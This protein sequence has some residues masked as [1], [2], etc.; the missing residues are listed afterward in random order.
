MANLL[1]T[2]ILRPAGRYVTVV[3]YKPDEQSEKGIVLPEQAR[4]KYTAGVIRDVGPDCNT[5]TQGEHV[6]YSVFGGIEATDSTGDLVILDPADIL[7]YV[8]EVPACDSPSA[9]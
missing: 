4:K 2:G 9:S 5:Y 7:C 6:F 1:K 3:P 8:T